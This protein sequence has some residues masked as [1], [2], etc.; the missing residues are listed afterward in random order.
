MK[1]IL[2]TIILI[3][4]G[5]L[6]LA[7]T[8]IQGRIVDTNDN[9]VALANVILVSTDLGTISDF[10]GNFLFNVP[11]TGEYELLIS[12][13]G[14]ESFKTRIELN[15]STQNLNN[16]RL[17][18]S[19]EMLNDAVVT[20][21]RLSQ[22]ITDVSIPITVISQEQIQ[23]S[24]N[25]RL[26]EILIEQTGLTINSDHGSGIQIQGLNSE[27]ILILVDG[28]PLI[29]RTAG[30]L[31][32]SR[33]TL[34]NIE[35]IEVVKGPSSSLYGSEAMGGVINIITKD[36]I[37]GINLDLGAKYRSFNTSD[38]NT[39]ITYSN[40]NFS[41]QGFFN[42]LNSDGY[43]L[44]PE[45]LGQTVS[46]FTA[47]TYQ[48][49]T[50][51]KIND[52]LKLSVSGRLYEEPQRDFVMVSLNNGV[53]I[54]EV[55]H[56]YNAKRKD[57]N[58]LPKLDW[59]VSDKLQLNFRHYMSE[60]ETETRI[61]RNSDNDLFSLDVFQQDFNRTETQADYILSG[62]QI[63]TF[64]A[65]HIDEGVSSTRYVDS[66]FNAQYVFIQHIW[67]PNK[68]LDIT[69]GMRFDN[70]NAYGD[71]FSPKLAIGY[72][73]NENIKFNVSFGGGFKAPDFRQLLLDFTNPTVGYSVMGT[74]V[75]L[76][77]V[78]RLISQGETFRFDPI[79]NPDALEN[80]RRNALASSAGLQAERSLSLNIGADI[81]LKNGT[82]IS[83]NV[84]R[85]EISNL[86]DTWAVAQKDNGQFVFSY[87]N[88]EDI[89]TQGL[90]LEAN[91]QFNAD[92]KV[93]IGYQY[94]DAFDQAVVDRIQNE[95][96]AYRRPG[97]IISRQVQRSDYGGLFGRS[98][99]SGNFKINY[100]L[101]ALKLNIYWR[102]IYRGRWGFADQ[103][104]NQILVGDNE[105]ADGYFQHNVSI[106]KPLGQHF[107]LD[108]GVNNLISTTNEFEPTLA[109]RIWFVGLKFN[110][111]KQ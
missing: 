107:L 58:I 39:S 66:T 48:L 70:H 40:S 99:H 78:E 95:V 92:L 108:A 68:K 65:G 103:D 15:G 26:D 20:A 22:K 100:S 16:I 61:T 12:S 76:D 67:E 71:N 102:S 19:I 7:Q 28:E 60:Y 87:R 86:I 5:S 85:N 90:E 82:T 94:L 84:F 104:G 1:G 59:Q 33:I 21:S 36:P 35:R 81:K 3:I 42:R 69:T 30:T 73:Y 106:Q 29:G 38:V 41:I 10:D 79:D 105:Y 13:V 63:L 46:A 53:S 77:G 93:S 9:P 98:K 51:Y 91:H 17:T 25:V 80:A 111:K 45:T 88:V 83:A 4:A 64:G 50:S 2:T 62:S 47:T 23:N 89:V 109:G 96:V 6:G 27:Y 31:D 14:Y 110:L 11:L 49:K 52:K 56:D 72:D 75:V 8:A 74:S 101:R 97:E 37:T 34:N 54:T 44:N 24:G 57:W 43:D 32:L 18:E 55:L